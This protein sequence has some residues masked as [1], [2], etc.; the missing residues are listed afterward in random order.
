MSYRSL[1]IGIY[2]KSMKSQLKMIIDENKVYLRVTWCK[3]TIMI[4]KN[5]V[6]ITQTSGPCGIQTYDR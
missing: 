1:R 6:I 4:L 3:T 5:L 2:I